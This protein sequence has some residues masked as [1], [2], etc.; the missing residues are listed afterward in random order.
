MSL[1]LIHIKEV[2]APGGKTAVTFSG[3][4]FYV[5]SGV[6]TELKSTHPST[7]IMA[8]CLFLLFASGWLTTTPKYSLLFT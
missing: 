4:F 7:P 5:R 8:R 3:C 6:P 1:F 2:Q